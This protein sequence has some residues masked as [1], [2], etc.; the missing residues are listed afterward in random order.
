MPKL[1][2]DVH[3]GM[4]LDELKAVRPEIVYVRDVEGTDGYHERIP[5]SPFFQDTMYIFSGEQL[6]LVKLRMSTA[7]Y[8]TIWRH[9][10]LLIYG[11]LLKWGKIASREVLTVIGGENPAPAAGLAWVR[12][13]LLVWRNQDAFITVSYT[14]SKTSD[15]FPWLEA[16]GPDSAPEYFLSINILS[17]P[18]KPEWIFPSGKIEKSAE[19]EGSTFLFSDVDQI[20]GASAVILDGDPFE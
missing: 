14:P 8:S 18:W 19:V 3:L 7:N 2:H 1:L 17:D 6:A 5:N 12:Y 13:P 4:T 10:P 15:G 20:L 9:R 16:V 11:A